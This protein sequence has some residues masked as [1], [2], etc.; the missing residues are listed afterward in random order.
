V[1]DQRQPNRAPRTQ[2]AIWARDSLRSGRVLRQ[3]TL[4]SGVSLLQ[5]GESRQ[6][7]PAAGRLWGIEN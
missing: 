1:I 2:F 6:C 5:W 4:R 3:D 7:A